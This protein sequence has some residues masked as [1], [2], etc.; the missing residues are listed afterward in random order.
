M[1]KSKVEND[2]RGGFFIQ[3]LVCVS[4][5]CGFMFFKDTQI[6]GTTPQKVAEHFINYTVN[7]RETFDEF[8]ND[9]VPASGIITEGE[10]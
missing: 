8:K 9:V 3:I 10:N 7:I 1:P 5:I 6:M 2:S 4:L